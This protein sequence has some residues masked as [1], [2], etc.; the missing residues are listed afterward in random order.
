MERPQP[1]HRRAAGIDMHRML[2]AVTVSIKQADDSI[3]RT[4]RHFGGRSGVRPQPT[5]PPQTGNTCPT[6][7]AAAS[8]AR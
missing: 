6:K 1:L 3:E 7:H 8:L 5:Q 2:H 4:T